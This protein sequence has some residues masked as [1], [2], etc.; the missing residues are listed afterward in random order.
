MSKADDFRKR[1]EKMR[2]DPPRG[3]EPPADTFSKLAKLFELHCDLIESRL[4]EPV[5]ITKH[6][7]DGA[8]E[9]E[10]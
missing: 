2:A 5:D 4:A 8:V 10:E 3:D 1:L 9:L 6:N 7:E